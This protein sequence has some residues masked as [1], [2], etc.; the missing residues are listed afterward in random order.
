M[1]ADGSLHRQVISTHDIDYVTKESPCLPSARISTTCV[2]SEG[3]NDLYVYV[4]SEKI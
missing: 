3:M 4:S 2:I 1:A